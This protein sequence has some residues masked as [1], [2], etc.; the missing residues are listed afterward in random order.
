MHCVCTDMS[1]SLSGE[2]L[3]AV[4]VRELRVIERM[5]ALTVIH[6]RNVSLF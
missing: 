5:N 6:T 4:E 1:E 3:R 2:I